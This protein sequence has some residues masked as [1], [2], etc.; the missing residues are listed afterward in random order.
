MLFVKC[1]VS[2]SKVD[3]TADRLSVLQKL[4]R[5]RNVRFCSFIVFF[6][7]VVH[8]KSD[9]DLQIEIISANTWIER[10]TRKRTIFLNEQS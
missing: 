7:H 4:R 3:Q 5:Q 8:R 9:I 10:E 2:R 1:N 6:F